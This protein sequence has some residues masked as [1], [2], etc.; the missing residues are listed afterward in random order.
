[1]NL[2]VEDA[3]KSGAPVK[4]TLAV[5]DAIIATIS[6]NLS[7]RELSCQHIADAISKV[8]ILSCTMHR[9]LNRRGYRPCKPATK[10]NLT[11]ENKIER[12]E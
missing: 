4:A 6:K 1:L 2:Y 9:V 10:P 8:K 11:V 3:P 7:T 12:L 5:E